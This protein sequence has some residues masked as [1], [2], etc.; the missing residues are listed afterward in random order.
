MVNHIYIGLIFLRK[1]E[2]NWQNK[3]EEESMCIP[4]AESTS[5]TFCFY[6]ENRNS[7][8]GRPWWTTGMDIDT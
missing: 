1:L 7:H 6:T 4:R 3:L 5:R 2:K 8:Q